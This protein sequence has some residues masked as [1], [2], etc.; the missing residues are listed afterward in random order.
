M[1][2]NRTKLIT[3]SLILGLFLSSIDQTIVT[4]AMPTVIKSIGGLS[5]YSW[6]FAAYMLLETAGTPIFGKLSDM[7]GRKPIYITG[8]SLFI[9]GSI[10]SGISQNI[11]Q[12]I[13]FRA[14][15]GLG[16]GALLPV[17]FTIVS[18]IYPLEQRGKMQ[19]IFGSV[20]GI[21]SLLGPLIGGYITEYLSWRWLF[22]IN[23]P[24]GVTALAIISFALKEPRVKEKKSIDFAG[25][26]LL[27][28]ATIT[29]LM[30]TIWGGDKFAWGSPQ[31]IG[32]FVAGLIMIGAFIFVEKKA[33][34]PILPLYLFKIRNI[35][36]TSI[37]VFLMGLGMF[38]AISFVP[39]FLQ[40]VIGASPSMSGYILMPMMIAVII[41]SFAG[42]MFINKFPFKYIIVAAMGLMS[43]SFFL[44]SRMNINT[45]MLQI[46]VYMII[47]GIGMGLLMP[48]LT[49]AVQTATDKEHR[50]IATSSNTFFRA[51]G[52]TFGVSILGAFL[53]REMIKGI[54][55]LKQNFN[56]IPTEK[57][58]SF[59][60]PQNLQQSGD[61][62]QISPQ[63]VKE[64]LKI[65]SDSL[66][67]L[68]F[69]GLLFLIIGLILAFF[70]KNDKKDI[71]MEKSDLFAD[72]TIN[73]NIMMP[74][75]K[76]KEKEKMNL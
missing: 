38:G 1:Q 66:N 16:A 41:A 67:K 27:C 59:A 71:N 18:D 2:V 58:L 33:K 65:F 20:F 19:G 68:F 40:T 73:E 24:I 37:I 75:K 32:L 52:G 61:I 48:T 23:V 28:A 21:A 3:A 29:L 42:G 46:I 6:V 39:L 47:N 10:L 76:N 8:I 25:A 64:V 53:Y 7:F 63:L 49:Y 15:Q 60:N 70:I 26:V 12:L 55:G 35:T 36:L 11:T 34:E 69:V 5:L 13:A 43:V 17:A 54:E 30:T 9:A 72:K 14:I 51:L 4:I 62:G 74:N 31:I 56:S 22:Y 45:S 44:M 57:L 50:G